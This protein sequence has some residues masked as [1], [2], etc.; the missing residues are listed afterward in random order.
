MN[1][2]ASFFSVFVSCFFPLQI[3]TEFPVRIFL[4]ICQIFKYKSRKFIINKYYYLYSCPYPYTP[5]KGDKWMNIYSKLFICVE[6]IYFSFMKNSFGLNGVSN[7]AMFFLW[8]LLR[9]NF[10]NKPFATVNMFH[11]FR[12]HKL[13]NKKEKKHFCHYW[14]VLLYLLLYLL[15]EVN[16]MFLQFVHK[17]ND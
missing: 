2:F 9:E 11:I 7:F 17:Q 14:A 4:N 13:K 15:V 6:G 3:K 16:I 8:K 10:K 5:L 1:V 12:N